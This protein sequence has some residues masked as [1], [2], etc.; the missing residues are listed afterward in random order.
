MIRGAIFDMDGTLLDSM[1]YWDHAG[2]VYLKNI[3]IKAAPNLGKI[4]FPMTMEEGAEYLQEAYDLPLTVKEITA[5]TNR[6]VENF[7]QNQ[8]PLKPGVIELLKSLKARGIKLAVATV[9]IRPLAE[10]ALE[11]CGVL[12]LFDTLVTA[13]DV[14]CGKD[15]PDIFHKAS[16]IIGTKPSETLVFEDSVHALQTAKEAGFVPVGV[17]DDSSADE[18]DKMKQIGVMYLKN[19]DVDVEDLF[20]VQ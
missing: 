16:E 17:Y 11:R 4:L 8:I 5:G 13:D 15:C 10:A 9:T 7:Y 14:G 6:T 2:E 19:F 3:G 12:D 1:P 18:Q 20:S